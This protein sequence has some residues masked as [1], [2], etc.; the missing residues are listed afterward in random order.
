MIRNWTFEL[1]W[2]IE[3]RDQNATQLLAKKQ[4]NIELVFGL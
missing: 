2:G 1:E 4:E 3:S